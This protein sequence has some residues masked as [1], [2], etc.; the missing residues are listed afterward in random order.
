MQVEL[1]SNH[2]SPWVIHQEVEIPL[3]GSQDGNSIGLICFAEAYWRG[4][5]FGNQ[6]EEKEKHKEKRKKNIEERERIANPQ[7]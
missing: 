2:E 4:K 1:N 3:G 6:V 7:A 5:N